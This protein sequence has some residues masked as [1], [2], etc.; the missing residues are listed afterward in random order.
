MDVPS[1]RKKDWTLT[2]E[3]LDKLLARL[4]ADRERAGEE[5]EHLRRTLVSFFEWRGSLFPEDQADET[6]NRAARKLVEGEQIHDLYGYCYGV[7]RRVWLETAPERSKEIKGRI[8]PDQL[9]YHPPPAEAQQEKERRI[10]CF[11]QCLRQLPAESQ[12]LIIQYYQAEKRAK[13]E[14]RAELARRLGI[15]LNALRVR[16]YRLRAQLDEC[17]Q[18]CLQQAPY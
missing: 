15:A 4:D 14:S 12:A 6:I 5:Y 7:A 8:E 11:E 1:P 16:A 13:I 17:I 10:E 2:R 3:S 9:R 18:R